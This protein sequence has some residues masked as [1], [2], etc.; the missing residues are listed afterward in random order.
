MRLGGVAL[1]AAEPGTVLWTEGRPWESGRNVLVRR[2][3]DDRTIDLV[4]Q[5]YDVRS[6]V[7]EYG[8]GAFLVEGQRV[9]FVH[10]LDQ[11]VYERQPAGAIKSVSSVPG[12]RFADPAFDRLR[13]RLIL[14]SEDH[15]RRDVEPVN[16]LS[17]IWLDG[18]GGPVVLESGMDFYA[19]PRISPDGSWLAWTAWNH[20]NMPWDG[21]ELWVARFNRDGTLAERTRV[22]GGPVESVVQPMWSPAGVLHF[23]SDRT[24]FWHLYRWRD[25]RVEALTSGEA[26]FGRPHWTFANP[27][28]GFATADRIICSY[29]TREGW[30]L[31][32]LDTR[33][34][35]LEAFDLPYTHIEQV[36]VSER[37]AAF[38]GGSPGETTSVVVLDLASG[39]SSVVTR[40][41][42]VD[43]EPGYLSSP[44]SIEFP[45]TGGRTAYGLFYPPRN[46]D[47]VSPAGERPPLR[48]IS[49]GG[50]THAASRALQLTIQFWTSRGIA[51]LDV[52]YGGS[53]GYGRPYRERLNG[54]WG[55]VDVDD[56]INGARHLVDRGEVDGARLAI[57]GGSASGFTTLC[58]LAFHDVFQLGA[59]YYGVSDLEVLARDTHKFESRY[60]DRLVGP[61]PQR[62]D[63]YR[64]RSPIHH[65]ERL[66][67]P[68]IFFQGLE[69]RVV[70][71]NQTA[72]MV[73]ALSS[74]QVP[75]ACLTFEGEQ[76]G[77]RRADTIRRSLEA[78]LYFYGRVLGFEPADTLPAIP[79]QHLPVRSPEP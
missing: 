21:A 30:H 18:D 9:Y 77:F 78:A 15:R 50:P 42:R 41:A 27:T 34:R 40:S 25:G 63:L 60:L 56:C 36:Q 37:E 38:L 29:V 12:V 64:E 24:G 2:G 67:S 52:D 51:V 28:Y 7:H 4:D 44:S 49:H 14:V 32:N 35:R 33:T 13:Q 66:S 3:P 5:P 62:S 71:P 65:V 11:Q 59:C 73:Q 17:A 53:S 57:E 68:V 74:R 47:Y 75:V 54:S 20:P 70:P 8:G 31:A 79:I 76:H 48:V 46:Q 55:I 23:V 19:G 61:Y 10:D 1:V 58:A 45:T 16:A 43:I 22:A 6:R 26:E 69:D 72:L 39:A